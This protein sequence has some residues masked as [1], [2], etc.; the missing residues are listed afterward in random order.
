MYTIIGGDGKEY[1]PVTAGQVRLWIAAGRANLETRAKALGSDDWKSLGDFPDFTATGQT[2]L[3][4]VGSTPSAGAELI[5]E[6]IKARAGKIDV[7]SCY[8]RSWELLKSNFWSLVG[9]TAL[10][11]AIS[12]AIS[13]SSDQVLGQVGGSLLSIV[14]SVLFLAGLQF[15]FLMKIRGRPTSLGD[16]FAG[17]KIAPLPLL[18]GGLV[19]GALIACGLVLL[20]LPG[21]YLAVAYNFAWLLIVDRRLDFWTAL[22]VSR[23]I[24]TPQWWRLL[25]LLLLGAVFALLGLIAFLVGVL[26]ALPLVYGAI[27]YAYEDL[28]GPPQT[29]A[30]VP[31]NSP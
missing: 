6:E 25:G 16:A 7:S 10:V 24:I 20:I 18:L 9:V 22:E 28:C 30:A 13:Q 14:V 26:V 31:T 2:D 4:P 23:R 12:F 21:I 17:F 29:A 19:G 15:Y 8:E 11:Y 1:G 5:A 27:V 3:P